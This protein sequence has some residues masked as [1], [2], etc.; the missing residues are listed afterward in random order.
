MI[1]YMI[2]RKVK[3]EMLENRKKIAI[4]TGIS[5]A[6]T[7]GVYFSYKAIKKIKNKHKDEIQ[8]LECK[9]DKINVFENDLE[10][11]ELKEKVDE[12]NSRRICC[13]NCEDSSPKEMNRYVN[14]IK[15]YKKDVKIDEYESEEYD[16]YEYNIQK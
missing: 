7:A 10:Y 16:K 11:N 5:V 1:K 13:E 6:S 2:K 14:S 9:K 15:D 4:Y 12:F 8:Y 3:N